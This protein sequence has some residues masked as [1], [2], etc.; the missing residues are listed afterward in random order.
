MNDERFAK[1]NDLFSSAS[2]LDISLEMSTTSPN[3][4][5]TIYWNN[6][7]GLNILLNI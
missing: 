6:D 5:K 3:A 1:R 4:E 7:F 2:A